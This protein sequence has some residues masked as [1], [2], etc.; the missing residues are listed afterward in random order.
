M[1]HHHIRKG[2]RGQQ[3]PQLHRNLFQFASFLEDR[4]C[5]G[6]GK[7]WKVMEIDVAIL[8]DQ[9]SFGKER[10]F[11]MAMKK[12]WIF[13]LKNFKIS[14]RVILYQIITRI[15]VNTTLQIFTRI[16]I[17]ARF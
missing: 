17:W 4:I 3:P 5:M 9:E 14:L 2:A 16:C 11:Q 7:A 1:R 15:N 12:F 10:I 8:Q 13:V 6:F